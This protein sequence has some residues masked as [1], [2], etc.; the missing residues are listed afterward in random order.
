MSEQRL[1]KLIL[2]SGTTGTDIG[3]ILDVARKDSSIVEAL[4]SPKC[5]LKFEDFVEKETLGPC[6][7]MFQLVRLLQIS[8]P[9]AIA[10]FRRAVERLSQTLQENRCKAALIGIHLS[11][12]SRDYPTRNP[13]IHEFF[14]LLNLPADAE[15]HAIHVSEDWYDILASI[16]LRIIEKEKCSPVLPPYN[17]DHIS[18]LYWRG[19]DMDMANLIQDYRPNSKSYIYAIKHPRETTRRFLRHLVGAEDHDLVYV[20]HPISAIRTLYSRLSCLQARGQIHSTNPLGVPE[21]PLTKMI[22]AYKNVYRDKNRNVV[23][24]E[25]TTIDEHILDTIT[26]PPGSKCPPLC[27]QLVFSDINE[28]NKWPLPPDPTRGTHIYQERERQGLLPFLA[29]VNAGEGLLDQLLLEVYNKLCIWG[30]SGGRAWNQIISK[31]QSIITSHI[32]IRDYKYVEQSKY[33]LVLMPLIYKIN[34]HTI[35][36]WLVES[37]GV[38]REIQRA[39]ALAR[40]V[41]YVLLP[42]NHHVIAYTIKNHYPDIT[43]DTINQLLD[44]IKAPGEP[45]IMKTTD[46]SEL[47]KKLG[48]CIASDA[49]TPFKGLPPSARILAAKPVDTPAHLRELER[50]YR[51]EE[52]LIL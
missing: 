52:I 4:G 12:L 41:Y 3:A 25:P 2:V 19:F 5:I 33:I 48:Q 13:V 6:G 22:E 45:C 23:L 50:L 51:E 37:S 29:A 40:P 24:F 43:D 38:D 27:H 47:R 21:I 18:L 7:E 14:K 11:Y 15:V 16:A 30:E 17:L 39:T 49:G 46:T 8:R 35:E 34:D 1:Q 26:P 28:K 31:L 20:S 10:S 44:T 42:I 36:A 32:E 9:A